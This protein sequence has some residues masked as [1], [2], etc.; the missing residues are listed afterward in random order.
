MFIGGLPAGRMSVLG[1]LACVVGCAAANVS[2]PEVA[3]MA[4]ATPPPLVCSDGDCPRETWGEQGPAIE[5][6]TGRSFFLDYPCELGPREQV[7]LI[8]N[9][10]GG[11]S[12]GNWQ[13][14]YFPAVDYVDEHN[15]I[16]ATPNAPPR[17]WTDAD[18]AYLQNIVDLVY[19]AFGEDRIRAFWLAGHSQGGA[20]SRRIVC[21]DYFAD[22]VDGFLSLSGGRL[23]SPPPSGPPPG[24][25]SAARA[26][27][28]AG[29]DAPAAGAAPGARAGLPASALAG[30]RVNP[31]CD[32]SFIYETGEHELRNPLPETSEWAARYGCESNKAR[33]EDVVDAEPGYVFDPSRQDPGSDAW[34]RLPRP[35][36]AAVYVYEGCAG[37][38]LVADVVRIDKGHT[39]GLEPNITEEL[40]RLMVS[41]PGGKAQD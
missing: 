10:H 25:P 28:Q 21:S 35:G 20:T 26:A 41:A 30:A 33:R 19:D 29:G 36:T 2:P 31:T 38:R 8:L 22:K 17:V 37:G 23:G 15:L 1:A 16:V 39:E 9:L 18:D 40:V 32:F 34:G 14:N 7:T 27:T 13:R 11:G 24:F 6:A 4:C 3:G 12:Y 5:P